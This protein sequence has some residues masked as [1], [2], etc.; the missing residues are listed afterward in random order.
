MAI[1]NFG[2]VTP[3][4]G[5]RLLPTN[6]AQTAD[7]VQL[8]SGELRSWKKPA[9]IN[10][11]TKGGALKSMYRMYATA[12]TFTTA[13]GDFWLS[14][15]DDVDVVK[16]P[17]AGDTH[18]K[19]YYTGDSAGTG[20]FAGGPKK[21]DLNLATVGS[22]NYPH[23][24]LEMGVPAPGS[25]PTV[26]GTGGTS[27]TSVTRIYTYTYVTSTASWAEEGPP[28]PLGTGT[29]KS[30]A[31]WV[32]A[33]LSTGTAGLY[34]LGTG[35]AIK[36]IYRTLTDSA[37]NTNYQLAL[38]NVPMVTTSTNDTV[39][40]G[41]LGAICPTFI[42]GVAGSEWIAPPS[43]MMG[44]IAL[45]NGILA[46]FS[47]NRICFSEPFRPHAWPTRYQLVANFDI[48][49][50]GA[51]GQTMIVTTKG[52]PYAIV[53]ARPDTMSMARIEENHPCVSKRGTV[54]F[55]FGVA[56]PTSD[57]LA[58]AGVGGVVNAIEPFMKRDE[59][60]AQ[61]F[62]DTIIAHSYLD[63]YFGFFLNDDED[64]ANF[65]F[66]KTNPQGP[67]TF[68]N[69][70]V[71]GV[72]LDPETSKLYLLQ[73]SVIYQWDSDTFNN[74]PFDWKSKIFVLPKPVN[75]GAIQ[76]D[77]DYSALA[78]NTSALVESSASNVA[79]NSGIL[80]TGEID[81]A[82]IVLWSASTSY[83]TSAGTA[84]LAS[85]I[86]STDSRMMAICLAMGTSSSTQF[87]FPGTVGGT[88]TDGT[89]VWK[90][91]WEQ[92]GVTK[93]SMRGHITRGYIQQSTADPFIDG[94]A[95]N[96]WGFP[97][98]G[99]LLVGGTGGN[100]DD[101]NLLLQV[102]AITTLSTATGQDTSLVF[103][104]NLTTRDPVRMPGGFKSDSFEFRLSGNINVRY[105]KVAETE[106]ELG[107]IAV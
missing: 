78:L 107:K 25:Q 55:P 2:G 63:T 51:Y 98:R 30:D 36:R 73:N 54:S 9:L 103:S 53:G 104:K 81:T 62:P 86:K 12:T 1:N 31:T 106:R 59:W 33:A 101:R 8:F 32:I 91:I 83:T 76:V 79:V 29:G 92:S 38:D 39:A 43:D 94:T 14:W 18:F 23:S 56:W 90:R 34:A 68:G 100:Y 85:I 49:S 48:V 61:C 15:T 26:I 58:L 13:T 11:P 95:G 87:A 37:G 4:L 44:L 24:Y 21:S 93:G 97:L 67:L 50:L 20:T 80:G 64:G 47:G 46:G 22:T 69:Y 41:N 19:I 105:F 60:R 88:A 10:T 42:P 17:I 35:A 70:S 71:Q 6:G 72:W 52:F 7:N 84:S 75:F 3:R 5:P 65:I 66:D 96:Q 57:G 28:S 102:Y 99:S 77:A 40:D 45:P 89:V 16:G 27:T 74:S 82:N